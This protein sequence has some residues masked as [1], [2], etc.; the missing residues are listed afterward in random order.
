MKTKKEQNVTVKTITRTRVL[1]M[2]VTTNANE[3]LK[4][5]L[6]DPKCLKF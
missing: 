6:S 3:L 4:S 1:D 2:Y 5:T